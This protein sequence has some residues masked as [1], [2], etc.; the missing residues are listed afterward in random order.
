MREI[1]F[2]AYHRAKKWTCSV[3]SLH[4]MENYPFVIVGGNKYLLTDIELMQYTGLSDKNGVEI[5]EGDIVQI[6]SKVS[7]TST[8]GGIFYES[9]ACAFMVDD[10]IFQ[11]YLPITESDDVEVVG[12]IYENMELLN[13]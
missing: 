13:D 5:Y 12:N 1:K 3:E 9:R 10:S 4:L 11:Q 6:Y 2:M 8:K 7:K